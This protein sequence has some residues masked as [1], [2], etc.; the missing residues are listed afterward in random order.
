MSTATARPHAAVWIEIPADDLDRAARFYGTILAT[1]LR[2]EQIGES[3]LAILPYGEAGSGG[4]IVKTPDMAPA[5]NGTIVFLNCDQGLDRVLARV[6][7]AGGRIEGEVVTLPGA[8]GRYARIRDC[9]G[10]RVG[11]HERG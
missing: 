4:A 3:E 7:T 10:N 9:E 6:E 8:M 5:A 11:L 2:R 1:E